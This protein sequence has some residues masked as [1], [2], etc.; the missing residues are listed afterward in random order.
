MDKIITGNKPLRGEITVPGDKSIS[1]R[2]VMIG[3]LARGETAI[4]GFLEAADPLSTL[5]CIEALGVE[6]R[7]S[8]NVCTIFGKGIRGYRAP[9]RALDAGNSG[10]TM[11]LLSGIL[12]G[13]SFESEITGDAYLRRRPMKRIIEPLKLMGGNISGTKE[14]TAPLKVLPS[15]Q[16]RGIE[17][18]MPVPSAQVKSAVLLAGLFAEGETHV[19]ESHQSRDHT[20]RMLGLPVSKKN[21]KKN[22]SVSGG[23]ELQ[24]RNF[25]IPGDPSSAAFFVVAAL[26]TPHSDV[27]IK[28]IGVNPTRVGFLHLL[29][30]MGGRISIENQRE[31]GGE[32]IG[33]IHV[34]N[35]SLISNCILAGEIIPTII[36]EIPVLSVAAAFANGSFEVKGARELR[37]KECD[38][39]SA[40]CRNLSLAGIDVEEH[41][42]G[43][44]FEAKNF[45]L[46]SSR[47]PSIRFQSFNDHRIAMAFGVAGAAM[48]GTSMVEN[49]ECVDISYPSFWT[50][51]QSL[52]N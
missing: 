43:F 36:D 3:S 33:D 17:Y 16:L 45:L 5:H 37:Y 4:E 24:A 10:T 48:K 49:A 15:K 18:E 32:P 29:Q 42:D 23:K 9:S 50:T 6:T 38:R 14:F 25:Y 12:V 41:D 34:R 46:S 7:R 19:V 21:G 2:A 51:L 39:I 13:Q 47:K 28:N 26:I 8:E 30:E 44:A 11:R 52:T 22:I 40:V 31:V 35:S 27:V 20:E 1:H